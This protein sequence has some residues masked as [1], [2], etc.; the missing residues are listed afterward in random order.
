MTIYY[1]AILRPR[2]TFHPSE[3]K[4]EFYNLPG[5]TKDHKIGKL[6]LAFQ[7]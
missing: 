2:R 5:L 3:E 6:A 7:L 1:S 4:G